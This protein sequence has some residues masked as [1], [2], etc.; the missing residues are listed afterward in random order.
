MARYINKIQLLGNLGADP[1]VRNFQNGGRVLTFSLATSEFWK[2]R[3]SG[4]RRERTTWHRVSIFSDG[5][6]DV[7]EKYLKKGSKVLVEG[8]LENREWTDGE[9]VKRYSTEVVLRPFGGDLVLLGDTQSSRGEG[10]PRR[11]R[12]AA[13][14]GGGRGYDLPE[15]GDLDDSI[16]F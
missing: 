15:D 9:G 10:T 6:I 1:E 3:D 13:A 12:Q 14:A 11:E 5:L 8:R 7:A 2:D 4:G 16:P